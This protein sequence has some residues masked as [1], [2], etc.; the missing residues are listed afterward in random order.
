MLYD[1]YYFQDGVAIPA[2]TLT[3][4]F[5]GEVCIIGNIIVILPR[6]AYNARDALRLMYLL[7]EMH[8]MHEIL[9]VICIEANV[10]VVGYHEMLSMGPKASSDMAQYPD[11][12][13]AQAY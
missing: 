8:K 9:S 10:L 5:G 13:F 6:H 11:G 4:P 7:Y 12:S 3:L 1:I 2:T